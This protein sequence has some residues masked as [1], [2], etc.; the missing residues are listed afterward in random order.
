MM[1]VLCACIGVMSMIVIL[2]PF[3]LGPGGKLE[4]SAALSDLSVVASLREHTLQL[5]VREE[6]AFEQGELSRFEWRSR[7]AF[8]QSRYIDL[9]R[10]HDFLSAQTVSI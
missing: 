6:R 10:R 3:W 1:L 8:L 5:Y 2:Y 4:A 7:K 9:S